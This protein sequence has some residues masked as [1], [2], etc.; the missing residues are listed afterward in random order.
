MIMANKKP[1]PL[2]DEEID[3][4]DELQD[5]LQTCIDALNS[6]SGKIGSQS[7]DNLDVEKF[8]TD[9]AS[10]AK[11]A[12]EDLLKERQKQRD[13]Q[14]KEDKE[15]YGITQDEYINTLSKRYDLVLTKCVALAELYKQECELAKSLDARYKKSDA[16]MRTVD[17][18]LNSICN[19]LNIQKS[20]NVEQPPM[21][22]T[23][24]EVLPF[25]LCAI[26]WYWTKRIWHSRHVR[27]F[28]LI[29]ILCS[30]TLSIGLTLFLARDNISLRKD[31]L[32]LMRQIAVL[33]LR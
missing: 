9:V 10:A 31:K 28:A 12:V 29:L 6:L 33:N 22:K 11:S 14:N 2:K 1:V 20:M 23:L 27:Q 8:K 17:T 25:I 19:N 18:A 3:T 16:Q 30:W 4:L 5:K 13:E 24:K 32:L 21:P 7:T 26:P 15:T